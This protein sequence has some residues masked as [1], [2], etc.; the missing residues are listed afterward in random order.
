MRQRMTE[1][2]KVVISVCILLVLLAGVL[3]ASMSTSEKKERKVSVTTVEQQILTENT[4]IAKEQEIE[5]KQELEVAKEQNVGDKADAITEQ[6]VNDKTEVENNQ[7]ELTMDR[8]IAM[9]KEGSL[10]EADYF[11]FVNASVANKEKAKEYGW[12]NYYVNFYLEYKDEVYRLG[13]SHSVE[14]DILQDIYLTRES[15]RETRLIYSTDDRYIMLEDIEE[16]LN[17]KIEI[18]D[19]LSIELPEGYSLGNYMANIGID[20]GALIE[21][22]AYEIKYEDGY[23]SGIPEWA[24]SGVIAIIQYPQDWFVFENGRLVDKQMRYWNHTSEEK[25]EMLDGLAMPA[26]L[27][28]ANHDLYTASEAG[29]LMEQGVELMED[30]LTSDYWYIYFASEESEIAYY[31]SLDARQFSKEQAIEIAKSVRFAE[32]VEGTEETN[33]K[34]EM[35]QESVE[36]E[37]ETQIIHDFEKIEE[38]H[39]WFLGFHEIGRISD[40]AQKKERNG[41]PYF[42]VEQYDI[43]TMKELQD[44]VKQYATM[45]QSQ[46]LFIEHEPE[47]FFEE[48]GV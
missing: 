15:D 2:L 44:Y 33:Q 30:E 8:V 42:P 45:E 25:I 10:G 13:A 32:N 43:Q 7:N 6:K 37:A 46:V 16:Y 11:S 29:E 31:L 41:Y 9:C 19:L 14:G 36:N 22:R 23:G 38:L 21:P 28:R 24:H 47:I 1:N 26:I 40:E 12:L 35:L 48:E 34:A 27:Y 39:A 18:S 5:Q 3:L 20:G 17:N 4:E